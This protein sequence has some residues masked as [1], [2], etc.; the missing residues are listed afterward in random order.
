[1]GATPEPEAAHPSV[2]YLVAMQGTGMTVGEIIELLDATP[3][4]GPLLG[5]NEI[6]LTGV[7]RPGGTYDCEGEV[8]AI[9]RKRGARAGVF[10]RFTFRVRVRETDGGGSVATCR[11]TWIVP[12]REG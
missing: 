2:A 12:R 9:E 4:D 11:Y 7:L 3:E 10:D 8:M 5:E 6:E 1:M